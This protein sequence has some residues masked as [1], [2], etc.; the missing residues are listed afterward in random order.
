[1]DIFSII[2]TNK[3]LSASIEQLNAAHIIVNDKLFNDYVY[4]RGVMADI[5][6]QGLASKSGTA[7]SMGRK[8]KDALC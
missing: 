2:K 7:Q 5:R 8:A 1:M 6:D 3:R 4:L